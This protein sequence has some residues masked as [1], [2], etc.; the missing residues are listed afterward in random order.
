M[1]ITNIHNNQI[2]EEGK[3]AANTPDKSPLTELAISRIASTPS[4]LTPAAWRFPTAINLKIPNQFECFKS[5]SCENSYNSGDTVTILT[6]KIRII[7]P[8]EIETALFRLLH[9]ANAA[10]ET[11]ALQQM[12]SSN[13][14]TRTQ[15]TAGLSLTEVLE[16]DEQ[17]EKINREI[18]KFLT[19]VRHLQLESLKKEAEKI[20]KSGVANCE[21]LCIVAFSILHKI[22]DSITISISNI[23]N[24]DHYLM[25]LSAEI[26]SEIISVRFDPW[27]RSITPIERPLFD[28]KATL[29]CPDSTEMESAIVNREI[30]HVPIIEPMSSDQ[31]LEVQFQ[32][33]P[34]TYP[35]KRQKQ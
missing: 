14:L 32:C 5:S 6:G 27:S 19:P 35:N 4:T 20:L 31:E 9:I 18:K 33:K 17:I 13:F 34:S 10:L 24:G 8:K 26:N 3:Q 22:S 7:K 2:K 23:V 29:I 21:A 12:R 25:D 28:Y 30:L 16:L 15:S 1:N 11:P